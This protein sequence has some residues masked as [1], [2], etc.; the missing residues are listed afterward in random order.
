MEPSARPVT[1]RAQRTRRTVKSPLKS[2]KGARLRSWLTWAFAAACTLLVTALSPGLAGGAERT[3]PYVVV[4]DT[5]PGSPFPVQAETAARERVYGF[6]AG[7]RFR[8][9]I[10]GFAARLTAEDARAL[11]ADPEVALVSP[12]RKLHAARMPVDPSETVPTGVARIGGGGS[13]GVHAASGAAVAVL[14][15]GI[16]LSNPDLVAGAGANCVGGGAAGGRCPRRSWDLRGRRHR[17]AERGRGG[18]R[19][20][21]GNPAVRREGARR[22]RRTAGCTRSSAAS[23]G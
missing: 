15:T 11:R 12:D 3:R 19:S 17:R 6:R 13:A 9:A 14:D 8:H 7:S 22:A 18:C 2:T 10:D 1:A 16:D 21:T 20:R 5:P 4:Y 23:T